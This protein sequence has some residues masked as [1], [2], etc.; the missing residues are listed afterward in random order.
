MEALLPSMGQRPRR[1]SF[2]LNRYSYRVTTLCDGFAKS[3][4][5]PGLPGGDSRSLLQKRLLEILGC[6][7]LAR[8]RFTF[9]AKRAELTNTKRETPPRK[10]VASVNL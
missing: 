5:A 9:S 8:W 1:F 6:H 2:H 10:G 7:R 4:D 3:S